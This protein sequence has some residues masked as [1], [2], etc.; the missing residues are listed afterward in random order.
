MRAAIVTDNKGIDNPSLLV[1]DPLLKPKSNILR[2]K[3][4]SDYKKL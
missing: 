3:V 1:C 2:R 4:S